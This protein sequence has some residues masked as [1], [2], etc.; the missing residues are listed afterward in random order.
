GAPRETGGPAGLAPPV[1]LHVAPHP[2]SEADLR[3]PAKLPLRQLA[4]DQLPAE[5][6]RPL[7][8]VLD[9]NV[10]DQLLDSLSDLPD[11][12]LLL[13]VEIIDLVHGDALQGQY[14][15]LGQVLDVDELAELRAVARDR[16]WLTPQRA[17]DEDRSEERRLGQEGRARGS[18]SD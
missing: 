11:R 17:P 16:P 6:A 5:I 8:D 10:P 18:T 15:A 7:R 1:P 13:A 12:D 9:R 4:R 2:L 3:L 14:V